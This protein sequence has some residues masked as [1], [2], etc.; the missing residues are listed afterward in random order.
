MELIICA[1]T[2]KNLIN[3]SFGNLN[4]SFKTIYHIKNTEK[5]VV[6]KKYIP[7]FYNMTHM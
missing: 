3:Y 4:K 7:F 2:L 5:C 6:T 1:K